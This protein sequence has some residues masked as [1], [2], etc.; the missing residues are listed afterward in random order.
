MLQAKTPYRWSPA[1]KP[2][3]CSDTFGSN[4]TGLIAH[5]RHMAPSP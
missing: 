5:E 3:L 4:Q 1:E 2:G